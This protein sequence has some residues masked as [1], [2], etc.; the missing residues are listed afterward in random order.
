MGNNIIGWAILLFLVAMFLTFFG[1]IVRMT[2]KIF[3][4]HRGKLRY[5][6]IM[7]WI[8]YII[9]IFSGVAMFLNGKGVGVFIFCPSVCM[10]CIMVSYVEKK[11]YKIR[12]QK[13]WFN[14]SQYNFAKQVYWIGIFGLVI[15]ILM[16]PLLFLP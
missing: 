6:Y 10:G 1:Q 5:I 12:N 11:V 4:G 7:G 3:R 9:S 14:V 13:D 8:L 2:Y 16:I 15:M